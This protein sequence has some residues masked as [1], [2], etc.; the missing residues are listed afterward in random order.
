MKADEKR[1][2]PHPPSKS[3]TQLSVGAAQVDLPRL[4]SHFQV[5]IRS[6]VAASLSLAI[7]QYFKLEYPIFAAIAAVIA[8]D[9][10]PTSSRQLGIVR[11][12]ATAVGAT[13]GLVLS[14]VLPAGPIAVGCSIFIAMLV[15]QLFGAPDSAKVAGFL[16][17]I[18]IFAVEGDPW[19][20]ALFRFVE[21]A[22]GVG[23]AWLI[24]YVP[25]LFPTHEPANEE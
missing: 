10:T 13:C 4:P 7:A 17:A 20:Y 23:V 19:R 3:T 5:A 1:Q 11:L 25:K 2:A 14:F 24:S 12:V 15:C 22:L 16:S 18:V 9:L 21:T 6:A 8:T